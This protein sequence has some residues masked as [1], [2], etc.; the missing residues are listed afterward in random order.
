[1]YSREPVSKQRWRIIERRPED[2]FNYNLVEELLLSI[3]LNTCTALSIWHLS[4][5]DQ[6]GLKVFQTIAHVAFIF[7]RP[8][9]NRHHFWSYS[10]SF[11][12]TR[13]SLLVLLYHILQVL[14]ICILDRYIGICVSLIWNRLAC[15]SWRAIPGLHI[16]PCFCLLLISTLDWHCQQ[17]VVT[18]PPVACQRR[19]EAAL[20]GNRLPLHLYCQVF[21]WLCSLTGK[22]TKQLQHWSLSGDNKTASHRLCTTSYICKVCKVSVRQAN[23]VVLTQCTCAT[24]PSQIDFAFCKLALIHRG[25]LQ[26]ACIK[27]FCS[28]LRTLP[29]Q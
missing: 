27:M 16:R 12:P 6:Y 3:H 4:L 25:T 17:A 21:S 24:P 13:R 14:L 29:R 20:S 15:L 8:V 18:D 19:Q 5:R 22:C 9:T 23:D 28:Q 11:M 2:R 7:F 10:T 26:H 1:M